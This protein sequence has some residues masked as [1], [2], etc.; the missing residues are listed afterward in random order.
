MAR[1]RN[2]E[3][4][5]R[6]R[7]AILDVAEGLVF[8]K[9]YERLAI[10]DLM[11]ETG[12]SKG[13]LYYYFGSKREVLQGLLERRLARWDARLGPVCDGHGSPTTRLREFLRTLAGAK[14]ED[15]GF[16]V[17]VLRSVYAEENLIVYA[18]TRTSLADRLLPRLTAI[19]ADG[20]A[21]GSFTVAAPE[22]TA[23]VVL[24]LLQECAD[25]IGRL[26]IAVADGEARPADVET[27]ATAYVE[28]L[29]RT[30]GAAPGTLDFIGTD[31]L[32][33]WVRAACDQQA[34]VDRAEVS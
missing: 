11:T 25:R 27:Q 3:E 33:R 20:C 17:D 19:I 2:D 23:R 15:R 24:S 31:D 32:R 16:L 7:D 10:S 13:A 1:V 30:L 8:S 22:A 9:G 4:Y 28:A 29:H 6:K 21:D 5:A 26:L 34:P 18:S 12:I 14:S